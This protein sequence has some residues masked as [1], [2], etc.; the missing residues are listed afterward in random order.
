MIGAEELA[1]LKPTAGLINTGRGPVVDYAA[2]A[3]M[4]RA[5]RL[6]GAI[7]DVFEPEPLPADSPLWSTPRLLVVPHVSSDDR[8]RYA[9]RCVD[10]FFQNLA[11]YLRDRPLPTQVRRDLGY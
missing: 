2:L 7:L 4:L 10:I 9:A 6:S 8:T 1:L 11:A 3:Q 5:G